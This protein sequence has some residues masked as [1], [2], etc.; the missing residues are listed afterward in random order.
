MDGPSHRCRATTE[1]ATILQQVLDMF[2][3]GIAFGA[4]FGGPFAAVFGLWLIRRR[5][6]HRWWVLPLRPPGKGG[7]P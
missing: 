6:R 3:A 4:F 2:L 1:G 5:A 7:A